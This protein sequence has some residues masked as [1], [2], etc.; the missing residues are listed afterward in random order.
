[1]A[2]IYNKEAG[3]FMKVMQRFVGYLKSASFNT[4]Q[5]YNGHPKRIKRPYRLFK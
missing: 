3:V 4:H 2:F 1:M 5:N